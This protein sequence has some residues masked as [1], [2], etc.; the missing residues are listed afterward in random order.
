MA[1]D[2]SP[3]VAAAR[4]LQQ[5]T[6]APTTDAN[7]ATAAAAGN[8]GCRSDDDAICDAVA[9]ARA[10]ASIYRDL[11]D[12]EFGRTSYCWDAAR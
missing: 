2:V 11:H 5:T 1:V 12:A 4:S 9:A 7:T 10:R 3:S 8:T 6:T